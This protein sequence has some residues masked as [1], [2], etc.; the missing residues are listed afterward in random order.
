MEM[1]GTNTKKLPILK[2]D[3]CKIKLEL[4]EEELVVIGM[5]MDVIVGMSNS[6]MINVPTVILEK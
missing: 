6:P 3:G 1:P 2:E 5:V 4:D